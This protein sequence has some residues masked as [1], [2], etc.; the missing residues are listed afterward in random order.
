MVVPASALRVGDSGESSGSAAAGGGGGGD[1][2]VVGAASSVYLR[3]FVALGY[4]VRASQHTRQVYAIQAHQCSHAPVGYLLEISTKD[5]NH[6]V[7]P[8]AHAHV[9]R[10]DVAQWRWFLEHVREAFPRIVQADTGDP[11]V[12]VIAERSDRARAEKT[13]PKFQVNR[14]AINLYWRG[15][16]SLNPGSGTECQFKS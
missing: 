12:V 8:L 3:C 11:P 7:L 6:E 13:S 9:P 5:A 4:A 15:P 16:V 2:D 1:V 14:E 10:L